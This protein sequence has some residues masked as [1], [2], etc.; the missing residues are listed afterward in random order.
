MTQ[1]QQIALIIFVCISMAVIVIGCYGLW[2]KR[3]EK[4]ER[5]KKL[6]EERLQSEAEIRLAQAMA[7]DLAKQAEAEE[8]RWAGVLNMYLSQDAVN[9]FE[10][11]Q[12]RT[13]T[14]SLQEAMLHAWQFYVEVVEKYAEG[15]KLFMHK[16]TP[17]GVG[18]GG[19][20][21]WGPLDR[22]H[23]KTEKN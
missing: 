4:R 9:A 7:K 1:L 22:I 20:V 3:R 23:V 16:P 11:V 18:D 8:P 6:E 17:E 21:V 15:Y 14:E 13:Q 12:L 2:K 5:L 19:R 10:M